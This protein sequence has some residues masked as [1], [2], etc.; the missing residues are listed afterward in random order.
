MPSFKGIVIGM[1]FG[2]VIGGDLYKNRWLWNDTVDIS[3]SLECRSLESQPNTKI[4]LPWASAVT[5]W[6]RDPLTRKVSGGVAHYDTGVRLTF[7]HG[8]PDGNSYYAVGGLRVVQATQERI[9]LRGADEF[10]GWAE[11]GYIDRRSGH[12]EINHYAIRGKKRG[13]SRPIYDDI[14]NWYMN[15]TLSPMVDPI[16]KQFIFECKTTKPTLF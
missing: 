16:N 4:S 6:E 12:A 3:F 9:D 11:D 7:N 8:E 10:T 1:V 14:Y 15:E 5:Q 13:F 2:V